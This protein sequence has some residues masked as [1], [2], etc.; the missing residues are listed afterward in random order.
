MP[1]Y[2]YRCLKCGHR[3]ELIRK[4]S[5]PPLKKCIKCSGKVEKLMSAPAIAFKGAGWYVTEHG[6]K[7]GTADRD[8]SGGAESGKSE[9]KPGADSKPG[10]E[11]KQESSAPGTKD[12]PSSEKAE[13]AG[14]ADKSDKKGKRKS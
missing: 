12:V 1:L 14:K 10:S 2:E 8:K 13:K 4:F 6:N 3:F 5:D 9:S 11:S 7:K